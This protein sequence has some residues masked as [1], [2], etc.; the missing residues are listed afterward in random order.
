MTFRDQ[1]RG[2]GGDGLDRRL[3]PTN[4]IDGSDMKTNTRASL[5][6]GKIDNTNKMEIIE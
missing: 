3:V 5:C 2:G 6:S 1:F 4:L